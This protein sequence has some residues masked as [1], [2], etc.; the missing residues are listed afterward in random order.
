[1]FKIAV[2]GCG[3]VG[4]GVADILME[5]EKSLSERFQEDVRLGKILDI[6][7]FTPER[8]TP[9]MPPVTRKKYSGILKLN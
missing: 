9:H 7:D 2:M 3:V 4:S 1:M 6:R 8:P 5:K